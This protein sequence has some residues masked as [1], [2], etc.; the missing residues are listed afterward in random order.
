MGVMTRAF[1][2]AASL[3]FMF[4]GSAQAAD[5]WDLWLTPDQRGRWHYEAE[6]FD[7]S[8]QYFENEQWRALA[9]YKAEKFG[10]A[11]KT[12]AQSTQ[13]EGF[14]L[15]G[16]ANARAENLPE[17]I[18]AYKSALKLNPNFSEAEFN[19][20]WVQGLYEIDQK[21]YEDNG[22]TGGK[23]GADRSI[24]QKMEENQGS[25]ATSQQ[26]KSEGL[27]DEQLREMWMRRVQT[28]LSD[29]LALRFSYQLQARSQSP[30][31]GSDQ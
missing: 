23:M 7:K 31:A 28:T 3:M 8:A 26:L 29:F 14:F 30:Q 6:N 17:A 5:F 4:L 11:A 27:S 18:A 12:L 19:L 25:T 16:N 9:F 22:G 24:T 20:K 13:A 21:S 2:T 10:A 15:L 1:L